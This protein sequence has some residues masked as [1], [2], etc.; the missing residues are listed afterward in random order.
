MNSPTDIAP[1]LAYSL[2]HIMHRDLQR[3]RGLPPAAL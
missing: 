1:T 2:P 3:G